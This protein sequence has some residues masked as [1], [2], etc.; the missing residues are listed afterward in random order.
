M[1]DGIPLI[2]GGCV[3]TSITSCRYSKD[4]Y[5][6]IPEQDTWEK[7]SG[8]MR[9]FGDHSGYD[10]SDSWGLVWVDRNGGLQVTRDGITFDWLAEYPIPDAKWYYKPGCLVL[11]DDKNA[12]FA[13]GNNVSFTDATPRAYIYN[14]DS[15][16]WREVNSMDT[17]RHHHSCGIV[18]RSDGMGRDIVVAGGYENDGSVPWS[19]PKLITV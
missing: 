18:D 1:I 16:S 12:F 7:T 8:K 4:C 13:G 9:H 15:N 14:R 6:Y 19:S 17:G 10:Y 11:M 3:G 5:R 2:C